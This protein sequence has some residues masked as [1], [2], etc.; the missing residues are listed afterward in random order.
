MTYAYPVCGDGW[1]RRAC[2]DCGRQHTGEIRCYDSAAAHVE[3]L[4]MV[5]LGRLDNGD[6]IYMPAPEWQIILASF[7]ADARGHFGRLEDAERALAFRRRLVA[8]HQRTRDLILRAV[9]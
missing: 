6:A 9:S 2:N 4:P 1:I 3:L 7:G 8:D 5:L